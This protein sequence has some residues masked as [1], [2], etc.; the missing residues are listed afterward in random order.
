MAPAPITSTSAV[1]APTKA[2]LVRCPHGRQGP[3]CGTSAA[4]RNFGPLDPTNVEPEGP[5][6]GDDI[7]PAV[8]QDAGRC[9]E[10]GARAL[11]E[12]LSARVDRGDGDRLGCLDD[13]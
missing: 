10:S 12:D 6:R 7:A 1:V 13:E 5:G 4:R 11:G 8:E 9:Q 3:G 2:L